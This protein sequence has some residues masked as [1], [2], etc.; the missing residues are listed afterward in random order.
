[1]RLGSQLPHLL[2]LPLFRSRPLQS[3]HGKHL[4][5]PENN[6]PFD[7]HIMVAFRFVFFLALG[8]ELGHLELDRSAARA[9]LRP[10]PLAT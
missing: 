10:P 7:A 9:A 3:G 2:E 5:A 4:A 6:P 8:H 1:V